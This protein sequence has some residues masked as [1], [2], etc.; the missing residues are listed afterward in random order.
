MNLKT[1]SVIQ[2]DCTGMGHNGEGV[3]RFDGL[4]LFVPLVLPGEKA[5]IEVVEVKKRYGVGRLI[6]I[7]EP[8]A[9]RVAPRCTY[10]GSCG[11]C[12][13][14]HLSYSGQLRHKKQMVKDAFERIGRL[15]SPII[16]DVLGMA[17]PWN[18]RNKMQLPVGKEKQELLIGC[19]QRGSHKVIDT[20]DCLIQSEWNNRLLKKI[21]NFFKR[22]AQRF[23]LKKIIKVGF[24]M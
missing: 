3:C 6:E 4:A 1:G 19:Y 11:G 9:E 5:K 14:Q 24:A 13:L 8:S 22:L 21:K 12:Q 17:E 15:E 10:Y 16:H 20:L 2:V 7:I 23:I 18:Y